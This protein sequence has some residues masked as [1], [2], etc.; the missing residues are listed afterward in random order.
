MRFKYLVFLSVLILLLTFGCSKETTSPDN[1]EVIVP[2]TTEI[3]GTEVANEEI[4]EIEEDGTIIVGEN[5]T[6]ADL[7]IGE[8]LIVDVCDAA[9]EGFLRKIVSRTEENG[10][11]LFETEQASLAEAVQQL[12]LSE[13]YQLTPENVR[14]VHLYN[15]SSYTPERD[16]F[17]FP[18]DIDCVL[19][20][21]DGNYFTTNDQIKLYGDLT[22]TAELFTEIEISWFAL[23]KFE[24]GIES[25]KD[26]NLNLNASLFWEF[27]EELTFDIAEFNFTPITFMAG[28][29]LIVIT[30]VLN[31]EAHIHGDLTVTFTTGITYNESVRYGVG[32]ENDEWYQI[33]E[34]DKTFNYTPPQ[35][36]TEFN[37]ETGASLKLSTLIY[38]VI[39]PYVQAK[40]GLH[41]QAVLEVNPTETHLNY[42]LEAIL[43][44]LCGIYFEV[45]DHTLLDEFIEFNIYTHPIGEWT[46]P[47]GENLP[48]S[49]PTNPS[50]SYNASNISINT[51]LAWVCT[52]PDGDP[53]TFDVYFGTSS[54]PSL[55]NSGQSETIYD[56]GTLLVET[57]YYWKIIAHDDH[58]NSTTGDV[59]QFTTTGSGNQPPNPPSNPNP[60]D[61]ATSVSTNTNLSWECSDPDGDPLTYDV[62]FGTSSN[63]SLV[64]SGQSET[65]YDPGNLIECTLYYWK[66]VAHD[67]QGNSTTGEIWQ[68]TT[69][70]GGTGTVTDIDGNIY[71]TIIIGDQEWMMENLKVTHYQNGDPISHLTSNTDWA[72]TLDGAY[73]VYNNDPTNTETYGNLYNWFAAIDT[74]NIA[75]EGWHVPADYEIRELEMALGMSEG[76]ANSEGWRGTDEGSKM[77]GYADLW[78]D[79]AL[80]NNIEFG[81]SS[82]NFLPGGIRRDN[83]IYDFM[84]SNGYFWST[85]EHYGYWAWFR[86]FD[87]DHSEIGR[88]YYM[89]LR[90]GFSVRC[91]KD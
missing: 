40:A 10:S 53:L 55:V 39:G 51:N 76:E 8:I 44:A 5:S 82:F 56:P 64:N 89:G 11:V 84:S 41:F 47:L 30:P 18:V 86:I 69:I 74:R 80:E 12:T 90:N 46:I 52:D 73:C 59:W 60:T 58:S 75:P 27:N 31:V 24:I 1:Q 21:Q 81:S 85:T 78:L 68:F 67:D 45:L 29:V 66:I 35:F 54:N 34:S 57:T 49:Q 62:Y 16:G 4:E 88:N 48:P 37:F 87:Y 33:K 42:D 32:Y 79:G 70:S 14:Q 71:Q 83:G 26:A 23:N 9:P 65:T 25:E 77:G 3:I 50:P 38:G 17:E 36:T 63:P 28:P 22:F 20:D 15:G 2:E 13:S 6:L 91:V 19:Y 72:S 43:Y 61:N 7:E